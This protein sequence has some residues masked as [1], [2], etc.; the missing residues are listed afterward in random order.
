MP[1][2]FRRLKYL[3]KENNIIEKL[4]NIKSLTLP[5]SLGAVQDLLMSLKSLVKQSSPSVC[6]LPDKYLEGVLVRLGLVDRHS[7]SDQLRHAVQ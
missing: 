1:L 4:I 6:T 3:E 2:K 5:Y 7:R